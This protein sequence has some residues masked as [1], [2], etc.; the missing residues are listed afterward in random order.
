MYPTQSSTHPLT[1]ADISIENF[2]W[3]FNSSIGKVMLSCNETVCNWK[4]PM[5][6]LENNADQRWNRLVKRR[7]REKGKVT[8]IG[9]LVPRRNIYRTFSWLP[10]NGAIFAFAPFTVFLYNFS[11][12]A[13]EIRFIGDLENIHL[14]IKLIEKLTG[15]RQIKTV[16]PRRL[17]LK[18]ERHRSLPNGRHWLAHLGLGQRCASLAFHQSIT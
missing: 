9:W 18:L 3:D 4:R 11:T 1:A 5:S 10:A 17:S 8:L 16:A 14:M 7:T 6:F 2:N 15:L 12:L 13:R